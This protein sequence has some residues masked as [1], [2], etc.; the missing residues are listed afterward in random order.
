MRPKSALR[1]SLYAGLSSLFVSLLFQATKSFVSLSRLEIERRTAT[2]A[3]VSIG[4]VVVIEPLLSRIRISSLEDANPRKREKLFIRLISLAV[5]VLVSASDGLLHEYLSETI[6]KRGLTSIEQLA[7]SLIGPSVITYAWVYGVSKSPRRAKRYGLY[8]AIL[9]GAV[10]L[11]ILSISIIRRFS[12]VPP[13]L[14][15]FEEIEAGVLVGLEFFGWALTSAVPSGFL[16]G[17]AIDH[18]WCRHAWQGIAIG[19]GVAAIIEPIV[20]VI[21]LK[22][23]L[24]FMKRT[25]GSLFAWS[26]VLEPTVGNIG[27]AL[28]LALV[29]DGDAVFQ[30]ER[31]K[32]SGGSSFIRESMGVGG[33]VCLMIVLL[34]MFSFACMI[35][36]IRPVLMAGSHSEVR[37][38]PSTKGADGR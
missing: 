35:I 1:L 6:S 18:G 8:A 28:G 13:A 4:V 19:L 22:L 24:L 31:T 15:G 37:S 2:I 3:L 29:T 23:F 25:T 11:T 26:F 12:G 33:I 16:G 38:A 27:W 14:S 34:T 30:N 20:L 10:Y 9:V 17:L 36:P 5:V 21:A 32:S 7:F